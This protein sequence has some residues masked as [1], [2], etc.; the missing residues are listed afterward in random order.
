[1]NP[2]IPPLRWLSVPEMEQCVDMAATVQL[3]RSAFQQLSS[4]KAQVPVR[5]HMHFQEE[6]AELLS[7]PVYL[8]DQAQSGLKLVA[9]SHQNP[10]I[11]LPFIHALM[12]VMDANNGFPLGCMN[13]GWITLMRTGAASG[14]ATDLLAR[15]DA[16]VLGIIGTGA[17]AMTQLSAI[18]EVRPI[19][20]VLLVNRSPERAH[21]FRD[22]AL[23]KFKCEFHILDM[24]ADLREAD[25][26]C[27]CT[28]SREP[29]LTLSQ[30][31]P[32]THLNAI[33]A[34][35]AD[36]AEIHADLLAASAIYIDER[37]ACDTE[38]GDLIQARKSHELTIM[39]ELGEVL[40]SQIPVRKDDQQITLFKS[41]GNAAQDL[42]LASYILQKAEELK[43]GNLLS[44]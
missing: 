38:A 26:I 28:K 43:L 6:R 1:M 17:Q 24:K 2:A 8:K 3:M 23:E 4:G 7:M 32:G 42:V 36:M 21:E 27:T 10:T 11:G 34:Y 33:G 40:L 37:A 31:R 22:K 44:L 9:L 14:L 5:T 13:G 18:M 16:E 15:E 30:V 29:V 25:V 35:R 19:K 12:M 20:K 41:V 39:G